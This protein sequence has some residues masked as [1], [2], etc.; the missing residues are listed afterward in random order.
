MDAK[1]CRSAR[2]HAIGFGAVP[3]QLIGFRICCVLPGEL[4][5]GR[6]GSVYALLYM[7]DFG[8][9]DVVDYAAS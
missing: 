7:L 3:E 9:A 1:D 5:F 2:R 4:V 8:A 6:K